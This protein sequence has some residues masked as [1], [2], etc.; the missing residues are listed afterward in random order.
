MTQTLSPSDVAVRD[1]TSRKSVRF[2][3]DDDMFDGVP[4]IPALTLMKFGVLYDGLSETDIMNKPDVFAEMF[5]L[6]LTDDSAARFNAR[7]SDKNNPI[8][9]TQVMEIIPWLMEEYGMRP[10]RPSPGSFS[11]SV[12]PDDGTSSTESVS[13][14]EL[15]SSLS[16]LTAS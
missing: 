1:F 4:G 7:M 3:I 11:G 9:M 16:P 5:N 6:I 2:R 12:N 15:T 10:T 13:L 8:T 14:P